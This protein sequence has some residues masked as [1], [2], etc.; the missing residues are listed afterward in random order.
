[1]EIQLKTKHEE[2]QEMICTKCEKTSV[3]KWRFKK[4]LKIQSEANTKPCIYFMGRVECPYEKLGCK[5]M[6]SFGKGTSD[7]VANKRKK[8]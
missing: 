5:F 4:H 8:R 2:R 6:Q 1:M 3:T 7:I